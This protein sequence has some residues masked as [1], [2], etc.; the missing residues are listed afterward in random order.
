MTKNNEVG[1]N[2]DNSYSRLPKSFFSS[3]NPTPAISPELIIFNSELATSLGLNV[4]ELQ[5]EDGIE[6]FAGNQIPEGASP[7]AQAYAGHQFGHF[8]MLGDG[9]AILLGEHISPNGKRIDIQ[10]KGSGRTPYSRGG[11]GR[12]T[13]GPMLREYIISEAM[14]AFEIP[15]TRS[16]AVVTTGEPVLRETELPGAVLTRVAASHIRVGTFQYAANFG[17]IEELQTLADYTIERHF[18]NIEANEDKYLSLLQ[19]VIEHQAKLIAKWQL[20]GFI[21]GVMNTD[22][23]SISG[24]TIDFGPCAFMDVYDPETVFSSIDTQGRYSYGNQPFLA[25]WNLARFA[26]TLLPLLH[27]NLE[28][29]IEL[30]QD[31][32]SGFNELYQTNWLEGMRAKLGIFNE[33]AEDEALINGLLSMM[34][35]YRVDYTNTFR[36]LTLDAMDET[37]LYGTQ[38]FSQWYE[39]WQARLSRQQQSQALSNQLMRDSNPAVIPRNHR[40]EAALEAAVKQ[41]DYSVMK[42]LLTV[43][44]NPY[45]YSAEQT[46]YAKVPTSTVPYRT[47]CGT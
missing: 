34:K 2:F 45:E 39:L 36:A 44:S 21:H 32:L 41:G 7:L 33:E 17:T 9:R 3:I 4:Q 30:A 11:D 46:E 38:E 24:E 26:E 31:Q 37:A 43:L 28:Q 10:L 47:Y 42:Q 5:K 18:P 35:K 8:N 14:H 13:L 27:D 19:E 40:V 25:G 1:W 6:I 23:M 12:A 20:V 16:L 15:T 29:A 22:N